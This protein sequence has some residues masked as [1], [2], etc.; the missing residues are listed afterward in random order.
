[1]AKSTVSRFLNGG[2]VSEETSRKIKEVIEETQY[3]PNTFAQ[4]LKAKKTSLIGVIVPRLNSYSAVLILKGI[5]ETLRK[6][7]YQLLIANTEQSIDYEIDSLYSFANQ[8]VAGIILFGTTVTQ[9]HIQAIKKIKLPVLNLGQ[10]HPELPSLIYDD[11][12]A[13]QLVGNFL[14]QS[15]H[16]QMVYLGVSEKDIAVGLRRKQGFLEA[17]SAE[18]TQIDYYETDF[19]MENALALFTKLLTEGKIDGKTAIACAT[20]NIALGVMK[21]ARMHKLRIPE[22][23]SVIGFGD[24]DIADLVGLST[25]HYPYYEAGKQAAKCLI[26]LSE[27][28][29]FKVKNSEKVYLVVRESVK[30]LA[31]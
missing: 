8:K 19:Q 6:K 30:N 10:E 16:R 1:V 25:V 24:Y 22:D 2:Y 4:S 21:A 11:F 5:S 13:G 7:G 27:G 9:R 18:D 17:I 20:D 31:L 15:G 12:H 3:E 26:G 29:G 14:V 23:I 28:K